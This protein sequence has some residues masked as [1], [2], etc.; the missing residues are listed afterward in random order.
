MKNLTVNGFLYPAV[1]LFHNF[2]DNRI[3]FLLVWNELNVYF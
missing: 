3:L 1:V 2:L